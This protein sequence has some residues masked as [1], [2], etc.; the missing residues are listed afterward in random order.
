MSS[1]FLVSRCHPTQMKLLG[2]TAAQQNCAS[3][4][5]HAHES[6]QN[7]ADIP[8]Q[9]DSSTKY[10]DCQDDDLECPDY[11]VDT[12]LW[13]LNQQKKYFNPNP[14]ARQQML[15]VGHPGSQVG[16]SERFKLLE[17]LAQVNRK[18]GFALD[19]FCLGVSILDR[20]LS[21]QPLHLEVL[22]LAGLSAAFIAA[23][24]EE[25]EPPVIPDLV[26]L[27]AQT[28][29]HWQFKKMEQTILSWLNFEIY[30]P[31]PSFFLAHL[32]Q[33]EGVKA[34]WPKEFTRSLLERALCEYEFLK[35]SPA[36][37]A[38]ALFALIR[39]RLYDAR[40]QDK[41][42]SNTEEW[43]KEVVNEYI[44]RLVAHVNNNMLSGGIQTY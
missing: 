8:C 22:Q 33:L 28:Y 3:W 32:I 40:I 17:W 26:A 31:T 41:S 16:T 14:L 21:I 39:E 6:A 9:D 37:L 34:V 35:V 29:T 10:N 43:A 27:C 11:A 38:H 36:A 5:A 42:F 4:N 12:F 2:Y 1:T 20:F 19:T 7:S 23:K 44:F 13:K 30:A 25:L 24:A 18:L 15:S